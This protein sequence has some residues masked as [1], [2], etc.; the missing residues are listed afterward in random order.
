[1]YGLLRQC[2]LSNFLFFLEFYVALKY[3]SW[4]NS[5]I[6]P[7]NAT[8]EAMTARTLASPKPDECEREEG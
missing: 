3:S 4:N 2:E 5:S 6:T 1:M 8:H 7:C